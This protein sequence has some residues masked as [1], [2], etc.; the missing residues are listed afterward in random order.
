MTDDLNPPLPLSALAGEPP[1]DGIDTLARGA[2]IALGGRVIGRGLQLVSQVVLARVL[3]PVS[4]G[5]YALGQATLRIS[6][7]ITP[8]GLENGVLR[9]GAER[10]H[11]D[12]PGLRKVLSRSLLLSVCVGAACGAGLFVAAPFLAEQLFHEARLTSVLRGFALALPLFNGMTVAAAAT[13]LTRRTKY[14]V[15]IEDFAQPVTNI[16]LLAA[17]LGLGWGLDGAI[18]AQVLSLAIACAVGLVL[19]RRLFPEAWAVRS[20]KVPSTRTLVAFSLPVAVAGI[21]TTLTMWSD[22]LFIGY[23][24]PDAELGVYQAIALTST[25]FTTTIVS[26]NAV[27]APMIADLYTRGEHERLSELFRVSTKWGLYI[28]LPIFIIIAFSAS[29]LLHVLFGA[30]YSVGATGMVLIALAQVGNVATGAVGYVLTMTGNHRFWL[31]ITTAAVIVNLGVNFLLVPDHGING[32]AMATMVGTIVLFGG[33]ALEVRRRLDLWPYDRRYAKG[34]AATL[35]AA[36]A[37]LVVRVVHLGGPMQRVAV[38]AVL[39]ISVFIVVLRAVGL[40]D[41]DREVLRLVRRASV[42]IRRGPTSA[43]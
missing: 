13:R 3:G 33:A 30:E 42:R 21:F 6:G 29:D 39:S 18:S 35:A 25:L 34:A 17:F 19:V 28:S 24:R 32:A 43:A 23:Y 1:A 27:F 9:F 36:A 10:W 26:L 20:A 12:D 31:G 5:L 15:F 4:F 11:R 2:G 22:R 41:E 37:A 8:L 16:V 38:T 14:S 7:A 40:D